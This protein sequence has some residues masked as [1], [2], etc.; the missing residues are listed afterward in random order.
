MGLSHE[1]LLR[2]IDMLDLLDVFRV[3]R[4]V[5]AYSRALRTHEGVLV[6]VGLTS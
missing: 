3:P 6:K 5:L 2:V 4:V 1:S